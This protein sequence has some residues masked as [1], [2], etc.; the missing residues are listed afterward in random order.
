MELAPGEAPRVRLA[1]AVHHGNRRQNTAPGVQA[2]HRNGVIPSLIQAQCRAAGAWHVHDGGVAVVTA[3]RRQLLIHRVII[4]WRFDVAQPRCDELGA[5]VLQACCHTVSDQGPVKPC[6]F[7]P[8]LG[9]DQRSHGLGL[10]RLQ[11]TH[12]LEPWV[13]LRGVR[14]AGFAPVQHRLLGSTG[15]SLLVVGLLVVC[16]LILCLHVVVLQQGCWRS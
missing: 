4:F 16:L 3:G 15:L 5:A 10:G 9:P 12:M 11:H 14:Q 7:W 13:Q 2:Q 8:Q 1:L 6:S